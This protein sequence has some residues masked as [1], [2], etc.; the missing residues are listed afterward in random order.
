[1]RIGVGLLVLAMLLTP[2]ADGIA[3]T[4]SDEHSP[5]TIA[6]LRY[7]VAGLVA[8]VVAAGTGR[9]IVVARADR[10]GQ[11]LR[12]ALIMGAMTAFIAALGM[13]PMAQRSV[14]S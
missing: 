3:K 7:L 10:A 8:V 2:A 9:R 6:F 13:V 11:L 5:M 12:T 4:L 1:M 14:A